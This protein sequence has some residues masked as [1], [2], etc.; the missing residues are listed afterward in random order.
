MR[1]RLTFVTTLALI[2]M[3]AGLYLAVMDWDGAMGKRYFL[4]VVGIL[5]WILGNQ[6]TNLEDRLAEVEKKLEGGGNSL[7]A[8]DQDQAKP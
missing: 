1:F 3:I 2:F 7:P 6:V 5:T 8:A 4:I